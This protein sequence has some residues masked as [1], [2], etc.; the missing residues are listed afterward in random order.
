MDDDTRADL[1][2]AFANLDAAFAEG[3]TA[4]IFEIAERY[5][6]VLRTPDRTDVGNALRLVKVDGEDLRYVPGPGWHLWDGCRW[7]RDAEDLELTRRAKL[8]ARAISF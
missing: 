5:G 6:Y 8:I 2:A 4:R 1:D 3:P 7:C